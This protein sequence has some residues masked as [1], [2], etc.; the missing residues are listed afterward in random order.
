MGIATWD[1]I[2]GLCR[3]ESVTNHRLQRGEGGVSAGM[4][5]LTEL[6]ASAGQLFQGGQRIASYGVQVEF[7]RG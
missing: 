3:I 1:H 7:A 6:G 4:K 2:I 5:A